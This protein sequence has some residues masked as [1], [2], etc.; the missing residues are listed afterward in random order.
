MLGIAVPEVVLH[1]PA[2]GALVDKVVVS[3]MPEHVGP[4]PTQLRLLAGHTHNVGDGLA[5]E[6]CAALGDEQPGQFVG[7]GGKVTT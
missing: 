6:L 1:C 2:V 4:D 7:A 5:S 3:G